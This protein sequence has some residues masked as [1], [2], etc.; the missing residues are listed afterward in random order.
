MKKLLII[1]SCFF[2]ITAYAQIGVSIYN[3][4]AMGIGFPVN[5]RFFGEFKAYSNMY[6]TNMRME[7]DVCI[8]I[9]KT[10]ALNIY[11][12]LG[13]IAVPVAEEFKKVT[14]PLGLQVSPFENFR[15]FSF[16]M[17]IAPEIYEDVYLRTLWGVRYNFLK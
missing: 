3:T 11:A 8:N 2:C 17:E 7:I 16:I 10:D 5:K 12:G 1:S 4:K 9:K 14:V 13:A 15:N 6:L